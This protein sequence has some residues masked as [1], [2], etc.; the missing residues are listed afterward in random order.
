[1][2]KP[3]PRGMREAYGAPTSN[4]TWLFRVQ[5]T[6]GTRPYGGGLFLTLVGS[7]AGGERDGGA[8]GGG[9]ESVAARGADGAA[10]GDDAGHH[11]RARAEGAGPIP[12]NALLPK[13]E[14]GGPLRPH[15][16]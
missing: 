5:W 15:S 12:G 11:R 16:G 6:L 1:M 7:G 3:S 9:S 2:S 8:R 13:G 4:P 10:Q 14:D